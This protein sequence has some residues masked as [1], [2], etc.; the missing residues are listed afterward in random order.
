M[1]KQ[2][3]SVHIQAVIVSLYFGLSPKFDK[4]LQQ[5]KMITHGLKQ[6]SFLNEQTFQCKVGQ[7]LSTLILISNSTDFFLKFCHLIE[8]SVRL[9][10][11]FIICRLYD[12]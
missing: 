10:L 8:S 1:K 7:L 2:V 4:V 3:K 5:C 6:C 9:S 11:H 12:L